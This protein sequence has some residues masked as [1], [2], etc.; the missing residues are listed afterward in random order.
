M[1]SAPVRAFLEF[2]SPVLRTIFFQSHWLL[3]PHNH[4]RNNRQLWEANESCR[5]DYHQSS[6][7]IFAES[8]IEPATSCC[9]V[10][11]ATDWLLGTHW[12]G[13]MLWQ[14]EYGCINVIHWA[15]GV[16][17][18]LWSH[19]KWNII[20]TIAWSIRS[21]GPLAGRKQ[22]SGKK[23]DRWQESIVFLKNAFNPLLIAQYSIIS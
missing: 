18:L 20:L 21:T 3:S 5:N 16:I 6:K 15:R 23:F 12:K 14:R 10:R 13:P 9:Q 4:C 7:R 19:K 11:N 1:A 2:S 8:E 17:R 22:T